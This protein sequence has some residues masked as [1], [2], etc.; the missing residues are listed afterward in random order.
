MQLTSLAT[1][2]TRLGLV[3]CSLSMLIPAAQAEAQTPT[4]TG[5]HF[6]IHRNGSSLH[7]ENATSIDK[8]AGLGGRVG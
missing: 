4:P 5:P 2:T 3:L 8:G 1:A 6:G 7:F